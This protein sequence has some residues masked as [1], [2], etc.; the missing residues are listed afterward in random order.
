MKKNKMKTQNNIF[1]ILL[2]SLSTVYAA[3]PTQQ[4]H[5]LTICN[6]TSQSISFYWKRYDNQQVD[7][8]HTNGIPEIKS[9][10]SMPCG[11]PIPSSNDIR[12]FYFVKIPNAV[13]PIVRFSLGK[14]IQSG[15]VL[16]IQESDEVY[17]VIKKLGDNQSL[18][19]TLP[20]QN[21]P[22]KLGLPN[23]QSLRITNKL[24]N[25]ITIKYYKY[26]ANNRKQKT[27]K[28]Y[29]YNDSQKQI[30]KGIDKTKLII[31]LIWQK[32]IVG[33]V[34]SPLMTIILSSNKK[35]IVLIDQ[36][37]MVIQR[38]PCKNTLYS[39]DTDSIKLMSS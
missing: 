24:K 14:Q 35:H 10:E 22:V 23:I 19:A 16:E 25:P 36:D 30:K 39:I 6:D 28:H 18:L 4:P 37:L 29:I 9:K 2:A 33:D 26:D 12:Y 34:N 5:R 13:P 20:K 1:L 32:L 27:T 11:L 31:P 38:F 15:D 3:E 21:L 8:T 7:K 17:N